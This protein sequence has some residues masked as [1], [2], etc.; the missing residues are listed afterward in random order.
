MSVCLNV[1]SS[2]VHKDP[3]PVTDKTAGFKI[4]ATKEKVKPADSLLNA[5]GSIMLFSTDGP[6]KHQV[7][8]TTSGV[9][10]FL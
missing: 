4:P 2:P 10:I 1:K 6:T 7:C 9:P 5:V 3:T 8:V